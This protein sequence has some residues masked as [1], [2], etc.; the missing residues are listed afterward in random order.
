MAQITLI[1]RQVVN[2]FERLV[3]RDEPFD[4]TIG[5]CGSSNCP[6]YPSGIG[7]SHGIGITLHRYAIRGE[8]L[9][10]QFVFSLG[11]LDQYL[12]E[13]AARLAFYNYMP[14]PLGWNIGWHSVIDHTIY[15]NSNGES[16]SRAYKSDDCH[17][18]PNM[19]C[20]YDGSTLNA[21]PYLKI[22]L[23]DGPNK[24]WEKLED[25]FLEAMNWIQHA[26]THSTNS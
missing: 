2:G 11:G 21:D 13:T 15:T 20:Y 9:A 22:Y 26:R 10:V 3:H 4:C 16:E 5:K 19:P 17:L 1:E 18:L 8:G 24:L 7:K 25:Y 23:E 12:P 6:G 14:E